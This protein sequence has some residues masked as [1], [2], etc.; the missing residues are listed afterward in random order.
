[1][2][3]E[4]EFRK[5]IRHDADVQAGLDELANEVKA[6]WQGIAPVDTG[7]YAANTRIRKMRAKDGTPMRRVSNLDPAA[8]IIEYGSNDTKKFAVRARVGT[9]FGDE[10]E[11]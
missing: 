3:S 9:H 4:D 5:A 2:I 10:P 7:E 8:H 11:G 6:Y 1:M